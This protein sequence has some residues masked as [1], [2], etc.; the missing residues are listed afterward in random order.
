MIV[1]G[2]HI[3]SVWCENGT[4]RIINQTILPHRFEIF[5]C[6]DHQRTTRAILNSIVRGA[7]ATGT[8]AAY[9]VAQ[10]ALEAPE[11][12]FIPY[13]DEAVRELK[14]T[15][16]TL[17]TLFYCADKVYNKI[18]RSQNPEIAKKAAM[19]EADSLAEADV[20]A[21]MKIG[22]IG[23]ALL[24]DGTRVLTHGYAGWLAATDW[25]TA[26]SPVYTA[27]RDG[28]NI[29][30]FIDESR[31]TFHGARLNAWELGE[32]DIEYALI[33]DAASGYFMQKKEVDIVVVGA[34]RIAGNG[35]VAARI[36][37]YEKAVLAKANKIPFYVAAPIWTIDEEC[38][39][40]KDIELRDRD[41]DE[42]LKITGRDEVNS[43]R[44]I[45][46]VP[47]KTHARNP[48]F[49]I[50]PSKYVTSFITEQGIFSPDQIK[51]KYL[52]K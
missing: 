9:A 31:P 49:D 22:K 11:K 8:A 24:H 47:E 37:T 44:T 46:V 14:D 35:D 2:K 52:K 21:C 13:I 16:K 38:R 3:R 5:E 17:R 36:G 39:T 42:L 48:V 40:G 4:V 12:D 25:G 1:D 30:V 32:E 45:T 20:A 43:I 28:K 27:K 51:S 23:A 50:T 7:G 34:E 19:L 18:K 33:A 29:F 41:E 6:P 15:K 10:A 26:L